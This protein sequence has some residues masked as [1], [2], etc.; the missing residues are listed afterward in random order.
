V[1]KSQQ[2]PALERKLASYYD[3]R[4]WWRERARLRRVLRLYN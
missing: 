3:G 2:L 4:S 1:L